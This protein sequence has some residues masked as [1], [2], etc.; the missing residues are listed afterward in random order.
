MDA[1]VKETDVKKNFLEVTSSKE[2]SQLQWKEGHTGNKYLRRIYST[3]EPSQSIV[4][5]VYDVIEAF[6]VTNPGLQHALKKLLCSGL[7][8][9]A[10]EVQDLKEAV[11]ALNRAIVIAKQREDVSDE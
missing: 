6:K 10:S 5:D 8:Q 4:V 2:A 3:V 1:E 9:K 11:D 7:R